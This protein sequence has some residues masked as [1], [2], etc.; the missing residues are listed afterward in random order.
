MISFSLCVYIQDSDTED[1]DIEMVNT[2]THDKV[3]IDEQ[4]FEYPDNNKLLSHI[5]YNSSELMP[6]FCCQEKIEPMPLLR[7]ESNQSVS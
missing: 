6:N 7:E 3:S 1:S 2:A 5:C 4:L